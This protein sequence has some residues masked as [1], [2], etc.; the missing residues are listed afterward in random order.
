M[1]APEHRQVRGELNPTRFSPISLAGRSI[2]AWL[3]HD[4]A[5]ATAVG[6]TSLL[7][8]ATSVFGE[9][10]RD[11]D[12]V[13]ETPRT[14]TLILRF[15]YCHSAV[16]HDLQISAASI[17]CLG[18]R[19]NRRARDRSIVH[20][21]KGIDQHVLEQE[22]VHVGVRR[23]R[24]HAG[25]AALDLLFRANIPIGRGVHPDVRLRAWLAHSRI[26]K[27]CSRGRSPK[28]AGTPAIGA[29]S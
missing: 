12:L 7:I 14:S 6:V 9:L 22:R 5:G 18:R 15:G 17:D 11:L 2:H 26:D 10:Q 24:L 13:W 19:V 20:G 1:N 29:S 27:C 4:A 21:G 25:V 8:G 23:S 28:A 3:L 16:R